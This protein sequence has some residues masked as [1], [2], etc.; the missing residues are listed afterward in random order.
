MVSGQAIES[1]PYQP[2]ERL[3]VEADNILN[4]ILDTAKDY[5]LIVVGAT[6]EPLL[7]N[8]LV[9]NLATRIAKEAEVT[10]VMVKRRS[11]P[12]KSLL[13]Q[14]VLEPSTSGPES[15]PKGTEVG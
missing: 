4:A 1:N 2:L 13:R 3:V 15:P 6:E 14:T 11:G 7:K 10:V 8:L 12:L 9:G 5:D